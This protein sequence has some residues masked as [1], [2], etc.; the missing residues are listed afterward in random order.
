M[1]GNFGPYFIGYV[2]EYSRTG[3]LISSTYSP[4]AGYGVA[5][6]GSGNVWM[7]AQNG[8]VE[9]VGAA[10]PVVTPTS[11]AVKNNA[12]GARP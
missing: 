9:Y 5:I 12:L 8:V 11:L 1:G 4:V 6:D 2:S 7:L 10:A 3:S